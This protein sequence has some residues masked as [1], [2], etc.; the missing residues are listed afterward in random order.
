MAATAR[1]ICDLF[2]AEMALEHAW[3]ALDRAEHAL[4]IKSEDWTTATQ[5]A[6]MALNIHSISQMIFR[7]Q[8]YCNAMILNAHGG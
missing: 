5:S 4:P 6:A 7:Y 2:R 8:S 3:S 1:D